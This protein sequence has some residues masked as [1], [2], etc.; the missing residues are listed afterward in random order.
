M[1][2]NETRELVKLGDSRKS[3]THIHDDIRGYTVRT[4]SG[5]EIGK[6]EE[7]LIDVEEEKVRFLIVASGGFLGIGKDKT[8]VPVDLV[9]SITKNDGGVLESDGEVLIDRTREQIAEA[10]VYPGYP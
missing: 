3:R 4:G 2:Q 5:E 6:V 8:S 7:L 9:K 10:P 1:G